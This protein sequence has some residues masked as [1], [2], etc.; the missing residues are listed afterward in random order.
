[1]EVEALQMQTLA[2]LYI[3]KGEQYPTGPWNIISRRSTL[4]YIVDTY[5]KDS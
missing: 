2:S 1:M 4:P 5:L 3:S